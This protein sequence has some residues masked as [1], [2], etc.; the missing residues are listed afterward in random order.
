MLINLVLR[1]SLRSKTVQLCFMLIISFFYLI[2]LLPDIKG[3]GNG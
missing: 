3:N 2:S 1:T